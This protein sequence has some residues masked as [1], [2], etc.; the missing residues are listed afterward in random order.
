MQSSHRLENGRFQNVPAEAAPSLTGLIHWKVTQAWSQPARRDTDS[1][2]FRQSVAPR[3]SQIEASGA[4]N[5]HLTW[6]G[7]ASALVYVDGVALLTDPVF[8]ERAS[9][10]RWVGPRREVAPVLDAQQLP[11]LDA[12]LISHDHFDH[13]EESTIRVLAQRGPRQPVFIAPLGVGRL[14]REWGAQRVVELDWW[15]KTEIKGLNVHLVP[16]RHWSGRG[17]LD[18]NSTLWGGFVV[19][20]RLAASRFYFAG[21]TAYGELFKEIGKRFGPIELSAIPIG[22]YEPRWYLANQHVNPQE[23][24]RIHQDVR[25]RCSIGVHWGTYRATDETMDAPARDLRA[26]LAQAPSMEGAFTV[27]PHGGTVVARQA[28]VSAVGQGLDMALVGSCSA[29]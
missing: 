8:G 20:D 29:H 27:L 1:F 28:S 21:D 16:A 7:H 4:A 14:L 12:V 9:P 25:S 18:Q 10:S 2:E 3:F 23:A 11:D 22:A 5:T 13:L 15:G 6:L 17:A 26:A 24:V 19:T